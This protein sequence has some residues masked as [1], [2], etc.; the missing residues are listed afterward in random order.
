MLRIH[1]STAVYMLASR[2]HGTIY[3][4]VTGEL[5]RRIGQHRAK[6]RSGFTSRYDVTRLVWF[7]QFEGVEEAIRRE[8]ALK[9]YPRA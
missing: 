1:S 2:R 4:G 6:V 7:E 3:I 8:K 5:V 9:K